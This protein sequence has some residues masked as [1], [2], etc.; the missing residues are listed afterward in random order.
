MFKPFTDFFFSMDD[1]SDLD[2]L[3]SDRKIC[4]I[5]GLDFEATYLKRHQ[6]RKHGLGSGRGRRTSCPL[7]QTYFNFRVQLR[8]HIQEV[9]NVEITAYSFELENCDGS[10]SSI[11]FSYEK[12]YN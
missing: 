1:F 7:C 12:I 3:D 5:C 8:S 4:N 11:S 9:H 6:A 10:S 2:D